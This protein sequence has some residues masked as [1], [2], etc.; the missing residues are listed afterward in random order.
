MSTIKLPQEKKAVSLERD[1]RNAYGENDKSSRK[2]IPRSK[3]RS[4]QAER[5]A[6]NQ[7]LRKI[8]GEADEDV[9]VK[10]EIE[11]RTGT[12]EKRRNGFRKK[13]D[14]PLKEML[15]YQKTGRWPKR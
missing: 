13:P 8:S 9:A 10:A 11:S 5:L 14:A 7:P 6:A 15:V 4:H 12:I 1:C 3:Q 2:N